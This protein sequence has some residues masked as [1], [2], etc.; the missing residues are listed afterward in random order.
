MLLASFVEARDAAKQPI[1][2]KAAPTTECYPV[3]DVSSAEVE[4]LC[5]HDYI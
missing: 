2:H 5:S 4:K 1:M 3:Q